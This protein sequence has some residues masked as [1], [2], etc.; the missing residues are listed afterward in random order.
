[1]KEER[2]N[3]KVSAELGGREERERALE[4]TPGEAHG[5]LAT[6]KSRNESSRGHLKQG[7]KKRRSQSWS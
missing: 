3:E 4:L 5:L 1:M 6:G 7:K 2:K